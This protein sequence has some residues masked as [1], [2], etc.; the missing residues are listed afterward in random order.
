MY[1]KYKDVVS[2]VIIFMA[3]LI[4]FILSFSIRQYGDAAVDSSF[5]PRILGGLL[6]LLSSVQIVSGIRKANAISVSDKDSMVGHVGYLPVVLTLLL[7]FAYAAG[8]KPLGF[9]LST[10]AFVFSRHWF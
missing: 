3:G 1:R 10:I 7:M 9:L 4:Y 5:L 2:A 8:M 6:L